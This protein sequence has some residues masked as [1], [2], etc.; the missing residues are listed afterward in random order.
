MTK[1]KNSDDRLVR[2]L[3]KKIMHTIGESDREIAEEALLRTLGKFEQRPLHRCLP[4]KTQK[5]L[6]QVFRTPR[7]VAYLRGRAAGPLGQGLVIRQKIGVPENGRQRVVDFVR[8][9]GG[10]LAE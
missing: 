7:L 3:S 10:Q 5:I 6:H 9:P 1:N 2:E 8:C 4:R